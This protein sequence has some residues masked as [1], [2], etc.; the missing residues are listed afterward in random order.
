MKG[1]TTTSYPLFSKGNMEKQIRLI[2]FV[3]YCVW[4]VGH[5]NNVIVRSPEGR[6]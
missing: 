6:T 1:K 4:G 3:V 2:F 5:I